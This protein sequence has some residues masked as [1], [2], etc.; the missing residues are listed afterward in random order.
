MH[1]HGLTAFFQIALL[2][3]ENEMSG[4]RVNGEFEYT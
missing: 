4:T 1:D 2:S 3:S